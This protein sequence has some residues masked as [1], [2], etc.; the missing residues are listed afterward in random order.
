[1]KSLQGQLLVASPKLGESNFFRSVILIVQHS[2]DGALGLVLN[3]P[4]DPTI[5]MVWDQ[6]SDKPCHRTDAH[7]HRGGPCDGPL[8]VLHDAA[9]VDAA[10]V[11]VVKGVYF[12]TEKDAIEQLVSDDAAA[13]SSAKFFL[14]YAGWSGGQLEG[15]LAESAWI[16]APGKAEHIFAADPEAQWEAVR[17]DIGRANAEQWVNPKFM[18]DD[19]TVN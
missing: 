14:G 4:I 2:E 13:S 7:L 6:V 3:R 15:E 10:Q 17:R 18:P 12:T 5:D 8:M 16:T 19:P 1:M 11:E 9:D